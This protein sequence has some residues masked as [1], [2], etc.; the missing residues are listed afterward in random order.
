M[1]NEAIKKPVPLDASAIDAFLNV[2]AVNAD[3]YSID[4][5]EYID[6]YY[7]EGKDNA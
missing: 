4:V 3:E 2:S 5:N 6:L 7:K 1:L